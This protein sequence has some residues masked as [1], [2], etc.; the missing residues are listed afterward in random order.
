MNQPNSSFE[1]LQNEIQKMIDYT[2]K[3]S[4]KNKRKS[5]YIYISVAISSALITFL[6]AI[7]DDFPVWKGTLKMS[8]LFFSA[9]SSILA[10]WDGFYNHK[11]LWVIYGE[12]RHYLKELHL[13]TRLISESEKNNPEYIRKLHNEFQSIVSKGNFKW[14]EL[15][16]DDND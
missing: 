1:I 16:M 13:K 11:E 12:T 9:M 5:F 14:K 6:V 15:R 2:S 3:K 4:T 8:T 10:A 7:G